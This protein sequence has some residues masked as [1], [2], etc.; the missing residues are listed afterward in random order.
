MVPAIPGLRLKKGEALDSVGL[1]K[2]IAGDE[3][4]PSVS[5]VAVDPWVRG[6]KEETLQKLVP[7]CEVL[8]K[9]GAI[10]RV[11]GGEAFPYEGTTVLL[12]RHASML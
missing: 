1:I 2:R 5:R 3:R 7:H 8:V 9:A 10:S 11:R 6:A 4:F 12:S